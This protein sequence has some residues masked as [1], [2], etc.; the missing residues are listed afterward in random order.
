MRL[1]TREQAQA[2]DHRTLSEGFSDLK[3]LVSVAGSGLAQEI[4]KIA[5]PGQKLVMLIGPG[6]NGADGWAAAGKLI[7]YHSVQVFYF[8]KNPTEVW[9]ENKEDFEVLVRSSKSPRPRAIDLKSSQQLEALSPSDVLID[10]LFGT[11]LDREFTKDWQNWVEAIN[12]CLNLRLSADLPSG[13]DAN[14]GLS[15]GAAVKADWTFTFGAPKPGLFIK[16]GPSLSGRIR[17][18]PLPF[19]EKIVKAEAS[20]VFTYSKS[21]MSSLVPPI[22][23]HSHKYRNGEVHIVAGSAKFRGAALLTARGAQRAGAGFVHLHL[24]RDLFPEEVEFPEILFHPWSTE[25]L[26]EPIAAKDQAHSW[27]VGPGLDSEDFA[28]LNLDYLSRNK[29]LRVVVDATALRALKSWRGQC[30][31]TWVLTPHSGEAADLLDCTAQEV[32]ADLLAAAHG[33]SRKFGCVAVL[34]G[35]RSLIAHQ[36]RITINR[37]GNAGLAKAGSGDVLAGLIG[38]FLT[39]MELL[40]AVHFGVWLHGHLADQWL[41]EGKDLL[42]LTPSDL[43]EMLPRILHKLRLKKS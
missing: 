40:P 17:I 25:P 41:R 34:K 5:L 42:S 23:E 31:P 1:W 22:L 30:A 29:V 2:I 39:K 28:R 13:L 43:I 35:P 37:T 8:E 36:G 33:L 6:L 24:N 27:V 38:S 19:S 20:T 26:K 7:R 18:I 15:R 10:C 4:E 21:R 12:R 9:T 3:E 14:T 32:E 16:D 11:G